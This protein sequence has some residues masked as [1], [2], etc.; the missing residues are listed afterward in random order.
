MEIPL[1]RKSFREYVQDFEE[2][3]R[4]HSQKVHEVKHREPGVMIRQRLETLRESA[5]SG[6]RSSSHS[7]SHSSSR[8][9]SEE[10]DLSRA[11]SPPPS[12]EGNRLAFSVYGQNEDQSV[13][14]K[15]STH[16]KLKCSRDNLSRSTENLS[17][18]NENLYLSRSRE[19]LNLVSDIPG[20]RHSV[21]VFYT[22]KSNKPDHEYDGRRF[23][24]NDSS[25]II[26]NQFIHRTH[27][28]LEQSVEKPEIV[29]TVAMEVSPPQSSQSASQVDETDS[30]YDVVVM[31]GWVRAL[32][33]KFQDK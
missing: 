24:D 20:N 8:P 10:R 31:K 19:S 6:R 29:A 27:S 22:S 2:M 13:N 16:M 21:P 12:C 25:H 14:D 32:I 5:L 18:S 9:Q 17:K 3:H 30:E 26:S 23:H 15:K 1:P 28:N 4:S 7:S 33:S 11:K